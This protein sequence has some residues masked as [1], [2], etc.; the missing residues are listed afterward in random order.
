M[1]RRTSSLAEALSTPLLTWSLKVRRL[2]RWIPRYL[3]EGVEECLVMYPWIAKEMS[4][5]MAFGIGWRMRTLVLLG[6]RVSF[7]RVNQEEMWSR[8]AWTFRSLALRPVEERRG[9][10]VW[11]AASS[12]NCGVGASAGME[13]VRSL[14]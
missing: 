11:M 10:E 3:V 5:V 1:E 13:M 7:H 9:I 2:S 12:A 4:C 8:T 14:T 6:E